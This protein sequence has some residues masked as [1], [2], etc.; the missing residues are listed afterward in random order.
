[1]VAF[2]SCNFAQSFTITVKKLI[3]NK[4]QFNND[5]IMNLN[6]TELTF[7]DC[8]NTNLEWLGPFLQENNGKL[9]CLKLINV[10]VPAEVKTFL[11]SDH[12]IDVICN[13]VT[14]QAAV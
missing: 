9:K 1:M 5:C 10:V 2:R 6:V 14:F 3:L 7:F 13:N 12:K 11:N 4:C 8:R